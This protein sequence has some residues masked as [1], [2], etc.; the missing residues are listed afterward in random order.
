M[1]EGKRIVIIGGSSG[2][3]LAVARAALNEDA[4]VV[5][6]SSTE[7]KVRAACESL[8]TGACGRCVDLRS[9]ESIASFFAAQAPFD[10]LVH[11]AG[12]WTRYR[13]SA[14]KDF[15][16]EQAQAAYHV[17]FWS[18][19]LCLKHGLDKL[20]RDGS[21]TLT[22]GLLAHRPSKGQALSTALM[23][24]VEHLTRGLAIDVSPVR[25]N[26]VTPG[27][28]DTEAWAGMPDDAK[29]NLTKH[30]PVPRPG[31]PD[32]VAQAYLYFMKARYTTG[33]TAI[34]DGGRLFA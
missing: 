17:R 14:G 23:G 21:V 2:I 5:I 18:I 24:G 4:S 29:E 22:A 20:A 6:A 28:I 1:L 3:G 11:T 30:Q 9:E 8:G 31:D 13:N 16:L 15:S 26:A 7:S 25:V 10:H 12:E 19:L 32:E 34:V 27:F 33:Q